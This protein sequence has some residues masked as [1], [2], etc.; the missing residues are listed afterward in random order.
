MKLTNIS[1]RL[2]A[3]LLP[4]LI[5]S[6]CGKTFSVSGDSVTVKLES[7]SE[8]GP[9]QVRMQ[10]LG[11]RIIRVSATPEARFADRK[12]LVVVPQE[13]ADVPFEVQEADG[14]VTVAT[15]DVRASV[16]IADGKLRFADAGGREYLASGEGGKMSFTPA[17]AE[18]RRAWS[19]RTVFD[20]PADEAFYGL[21][22]QQTGEFNHKGLNE[23]LY[24]YN[25]KISIPFIVSSRGY[26]LLF[27]AYSLS[28]WGNPEPYRQLGEVFKLYD[29]KGRPGALSG[30]YLAG[31]G[32]LLE[33]REE[34]IFY[35]NE[36]EIA[37]LPI[38]K[39]KGATVTYEGELEA[40]AAGDYWFTQYYAGF[41]STEIGGEEL[42]PRLWRP[43]WNPNSYRYCVHFE[44]G[45]R[46]PFKLVWEPDGDVSYISVK[47]AAPQSAEEQSRLSFWSEFEPQAD[48]YFIAGDSYDDVLG[49]YR[50]L[51]GKAS[52]YPKWAFG[53]WQSRER[54]STQDELVET[55]AEM[56][57]R[58]IPVDNIVQDWQ[59]W[60]PD[61]W[62]SHEFD[63]DRYP[64]PE[65]MLDDVHAMHGRFMISVWPKFYTNTAHYKELRDSGYA[66]TH[67]EASGIKD[68]LGHPQS[69]YDAYSEGGRKMFWRQIDES[70]YSRY[71]HKI[72]AWWMDAS[73]PNLR[74]CLPMDYLKWLLTP[75]ALGPSTEYLNA[76]SLVNADAIYN[77]QRGVDPDKR[78]FLL[79][80]NGF[81]GLQRYSTASWSGDIG[82]SWYDMRMQMAA[83]LNYSM[84]GLP[85]WGMDI[86]GFSVMDKFS[87][88]AEVWN[89]TGK[90]T[91]DLEEWRELQTRWHQFGTFV[92]LF[93]AHGQ[94]PRRELWNIAPKGDPAYS[95][96]LWY[97]QLRYRLMPYIYSLAGAVHFEDYTI[98]RGLPMDFPADSKVRNISDQWMFGPALMPCPVYEYKARSRT[99]YFPIGGFSV[100][101]KFNNPANIDEWRELQTRW[102]QFGTFVPLFRTHGQWPQ[103][104]LWNIAPEG[105]ET[106]E[107][108]LWYMRLRYRLMP[109]IY[110]LAGMVH[111]DDYT[112]MRGL[113]MDFPSDHEV[114]DLS[115]QWLF[116]PALMPCPV[117]EYKARSRSVYFPWDTDWYDFYTGK[118]MV[119]GKRITADAPYGRMPLYVRAGSIIPIGPDMQWS[120]EKPADDI[121]LAV[122]AGKDASFTLYEDE[123]V[124]YN[125]EKGFYSRIPITWDDAS[126]TLTI[127]EREGSFEGMLQTRKFRVVVTDPAHP[128]A[129]DPDAPGVA[130]TYDGKPVS[131]K[132]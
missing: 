52:L 128:N 21:G 101:G 29:R 69:F 19:V 70:L 77:G 2:A 46:K 6:C 96:I 35:E 93:R 92:P 49:G 64:D 62:G 73:E 54:Y 105:S 111:F 18:G 66:Y 28:R 85:M 81:A 118:Y 30:T 10:V 63:A 65:K 100:M 79:T 38:I 25:T 53:F 84:S 98:M 41:Q 12:S 131:V 31:D 40:P 4:A 45:E 87:K 59:Y 80:R 37:N 103:R 57:S 58:G 23:E 36:A 17:E 117:Y 127:G 26:G 90:V 122:Y 74:D 16:R 24:Q 82:T 34:S 95:T 42:M 33:Q 99:V 104:E 88:A 112:I 20:S 91:P 39:Y 8:G 102:H 110:S 119:G 109:Y 56:R 116:G 51:T 44:A 50:T 68:W 120:D 132:L 76:Y 72:D 67:A 3:L 108:I 48:F 47:V 32:K 106:Y 121:L 75:T 83:G 97:M 94:W 60:L 125:Y 5:F 89:R 61:Q 14:W 11:S 43:A 130:V 107:S 113:P 7:A 71:G 22:Q 15:A 9:A 86:G 78:V 123:N 55:L 129:Y 114:R 13:D 126:R 115:D 27:D 1:L 124:N